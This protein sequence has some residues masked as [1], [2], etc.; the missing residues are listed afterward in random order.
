M[1]HPAR[2]F[3]PAVSRESDIHA[4]LSS[5]RARVRRAAEAAGRDPASVR[6][7]AVSE[8]FPLD[9]VRAAASAGQVDFGENRVQEAL[10][11]IDHASDLDVR[12]HLIG[13]LQTNK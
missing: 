8:T 5:V 6:L 12:W 4:R 11:K 10:E 7:I 13:H 3:S 9:R 1:P 2:R